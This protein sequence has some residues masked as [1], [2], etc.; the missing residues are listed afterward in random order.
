MGQR[1]WS[2]LGP[3]ADIPAVYTS[4]RC[5]VTSGNEP[6]I[7]RCGHQVPC[8][9]HLMYI[10]DR[11]ILAPSRAVLLQALQAWETFYAITRLR[12]NTQKEQLLTRTPTAFADMVMQGHKVSCHATILGVSVG[13][14]PRAMTD[15]KKKRVM[16]IG[17][18]ARRIAV[19]P[20]S[21]HLKT[22]V[23]AT[24]LSPARV[25]G[26]VFD[27]R[28]PTIKENSQFQQ[29]HGMAIKGW[30]HK[31]GHDSRQLWSILQAGHTSDL[32]FFACMKFMS[33]LH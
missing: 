20:V 25:W 32:T 4:G 1:W 7:V 10:D 3:S 2:R 33:A 6:D 31:G 16:T 29:W 11:T 28:I 5:L 15:H 23:A 27:G 19:L 12:N 21:H 24:V 18:K 26:V 30:H 14:V 8:C 17:N 9:R 13:M 22:A